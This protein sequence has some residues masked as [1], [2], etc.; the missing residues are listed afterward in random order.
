MLTGK[1]TTNLE[2]TNS[3]ALMHF[4]LA[5]PLLEEQRSILKRL[6]ATQAS[7]AKPRARIAEQIESF[8]ILRSTLIAHAVTG[9]I[10][11]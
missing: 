2:S 3:T 6:S 5:Y 4:P 9:K 11:V 7:I 1:Q 10:K 8:K